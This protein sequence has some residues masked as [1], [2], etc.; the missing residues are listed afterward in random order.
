MPGDLPSTSIKETGRAL[1]TDQ[2]LQE[3]YSAVV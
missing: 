1:T 3:G 2:N